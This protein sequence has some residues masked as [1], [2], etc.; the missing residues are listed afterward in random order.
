MVNIS[1]KRE[2]FTPLETIG[3]QKRDMVS[4]TG[5][6][7]LE[8]IGRQKRDM[9]SLTGFSLVELLLV[10]TVIT[11]LAG[12]GI[13]NFVKAR[14]RALNR[15]AQANL[16]LI[17]AAERVHHMELDNFYASAALPS[18]EENINTNLSLLLPT[19]PNVAWNYQ[20]IITLAGAACA[21]A[22]RNGHDN[23]IMSMRTTNDDPVDG[24]CP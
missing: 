20:T 14:E 6:T 19:G 5:F 3:R 2:S 1:V 18:H 7:P 10:I 17:I 22:T 13:P 12:I 15:D 16:R 24:S 23:R 9:V 11:I 21:Q 4:L 8:T